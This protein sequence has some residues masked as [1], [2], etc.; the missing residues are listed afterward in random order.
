MKIGIE[1]RKVSRTG[2]TDRGD[3]YEIPK[4]NFFH[5]GSEDKFGQF[6]AVTLDEGGEFCVFEISLSYYFQHRILPKVSNIYKDSWTRLTLGLWD[7]TREHGHKIKNTTHW[8]RCHT[9]FLFS[10]LPIQ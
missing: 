9:V 4:Q 1:R 2:R 5:L 8:I 7:R 3:Q 6:F 10:F